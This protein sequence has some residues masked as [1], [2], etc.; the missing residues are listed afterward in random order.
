MNQAKES[1]IFLVG[2]ER[3]GTT[4]LRLMLDHHP[5]IRFLPEH[6]FM[7]CKIS[8]NG[9]FP[10]LQEYHSYL[11]KNWYFRDYKLRIDRQLDYS[12]LLKSFLDQYFMETSK[13][14]LGVTVHYQY[15]HLLTLWPQARFLHLVRDPRDVALSTIRMGWAANVWYGVQRWISS[16]KLWDRIAENLPEEQ[17]LTIHYEDLASEPEK[18]LQKICS[19]LGISYHEKMLS[20]PSDT[21]YDSVNVASVQAWKRKMSRE[22][23]ALVESC[24]GDLM[25][26]RGYH[27]I[28]EKRRPP[29]L[30][31]RCVFS[32]HNRFGIFKF[33]CNRYGLGLYLCTVLARRLPFQSLKQRVEEKVATEN[34]RH[35]K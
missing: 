4:L 26:F 14:L 32:M 18:T 7:V 29:G 9:C 25:V 17:Q 22:K 11:E 28:N 13:P 35:I 15:D 8:N 33:H 5:F 6:D 27:P 23:V 20:F 24:C 16:E 21:T 2:A 30:M 12:N 31:K 19:W 34:L 3:S 10:K 1:P